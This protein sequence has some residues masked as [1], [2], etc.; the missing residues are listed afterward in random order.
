MDDRELHQKDPKW[1]DEV[2]AEFRSRNYEA[3]LKQSLVYEDEI[4]PFAQDFEVTGKNRA[5]VIY[6]V[7]CSAYGVLDKAEAFRQREWDVFFEHL[8]AY[9]AACETEAKKTGLSGWNPGP[10]K[11]LLTDCLELLCRHDDEGLEENARKWAGRFAAIDAP[12]W[13]FDPP[14]SVLSEKIFN[15][16][17]RFDREGFTAN[18]RALC[19]AYLAVSEP[20]AET[21]WPGRTQVMNIM[22]DLAYFKGGEE[23]ENEA[24]EWVRKALAVNPEDRF[25]LMR[26]EFIEERQVVREQIRRFTHDTGNTMAGIREGLEFIL[27]KPGVKGGPIEPRLLTIQREM[28]RLHGVNRFIQDKAPELEEIDPVRFVRETVGPFADKTGVETTPDATDIVWA[29]DPD[30]LTVVLD[31]LLKNAMDAFERRKIPKKDRRLR[32]EI[33][34]KEAIIAVE[35]NAGGV[36]PKVKN[37]MFEPYVSTKGVQQKTGLGLTSARMAAQKL[38]GDVQ[39]PVDQPDNGARFE[40]HLPNRRKK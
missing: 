40:I 20:V 26:K 18:A 6:T 31:N 33:H 35:D 27:N 25:A 15:E 29:T 17:I 39:Y 24:L 8:G 37:R 1:N 30:Y 7:A 21:Y 32:V 14:L 11:T 9:V 28:R 34:P 36:D 10:A 13:G 2:L 22:S 3:A 12:N 38:K 5:N 19:R 4:L 16:R 23:G